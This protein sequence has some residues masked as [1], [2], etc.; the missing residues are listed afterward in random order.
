MFNTIVDARTGQRASTLSASFLLHG[1]AIAIILLVRLNGELH[2]NPEPVVHAARLTLITPT[3][4]DRVLLPR[5]GALSQSTEPVFSPRV[6]VSKLIET[7]G[8]NP[9]PALAVVSSDIIASEPGGPGSF[10]VSPSILSYLADKP[11]EDP[12]L[13]S[14]PPPETPPDKIVAEPRVELPRLI[15]RSKP[16]YPA[17]ARMA[18]VQGVVEINGTIDEEGRVVDMTVV[19]GHPL[20]IDAALTSVKQW[21]YEP[22]HVNGHFVPAP[23]HIVVRFEL[24]FA[25]P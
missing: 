16:A 13:A 7:D 25:E 3:E 24:K 23:V 15:S 4:S 10:S 19:R 9:A 22:A 20:L 1:L 18:R 8:A 11:A 17:N 6:N 5:S 14:P 12:V 2:F 21:R